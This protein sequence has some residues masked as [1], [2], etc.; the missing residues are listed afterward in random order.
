MNARRLVLALGL[1]GLIGLCGCMNLRTKTVTLH[2]L[3]QQ[4]AVAGLGSAQLVR[5]QVL[6][7]CAY[8]LCAGAETGSVIAI[9]LEVVEPDGP[10][11]H[12]W[13]GALP[14]NPH[15]IPNVEQEKENRR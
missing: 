1:S 8:G 4:A 12:V 5:G 13:F 2:I 3:N 11:G 7:L 6:D 15:G 14:M 9:T 10:A